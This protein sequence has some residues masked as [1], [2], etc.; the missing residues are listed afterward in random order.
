[1][2]TLYFDCGMGAAGDMLTA[3]LYD[4]LEEQQQQEFLETMNHLGLEE[5]Q[6]LANK[7]KKCGIGGIGMQV[8]IHGG[9]EGTQEPHEEEHHHATLE[10]IRTTIQVFPLPN[11]TML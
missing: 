2:K 6:V 5:V 11:L 4:L 7:V 1:M 9:E 10:E 8:L 3:A